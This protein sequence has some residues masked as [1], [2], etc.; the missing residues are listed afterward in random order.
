MKTLNLT[1]LFFITSLTFSQSG[2]A[3]YTKTIIE[4]FSSDKWVQLKKNDAATYNLYLKIEKRKNEIIEQMEFQLKFKDGK[5][6]FSLNKLMEKDNDKYVR[7]AKIGNKGLYYNNS[8]TCEKLL[9]TEAYNSKY[10]VS[11]NDI[12]WDLKKNTK[13]VNGYEC[14]QA[15]G[16]RIIFRKDEEIIERVEVWYASGIPLSYGPKMYQGLPGI[17]VQL[18]DNSEVY[19]LTDLDLE[20]D[21]NITRPEDGKEI[22]ESAFQKM[23]E[24]I[25]KKLKN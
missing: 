8:N 22:T 23:G 12:T 6:E 18:K 16:E 9:Q 20:E 24:K 2:E 14:M 3:T 10:L 13:N 5:S 1:I 15:I 11:L 25:N 19:T 7:L 21:Y 17:I 4:D